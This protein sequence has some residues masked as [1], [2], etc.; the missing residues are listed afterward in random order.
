MNAL[1]HRR[2]AAA[3]AL[4][5]L[6]LAAGGAACQRR[7]KQ[8]VVGIGL[9]ANTH[10]GAKLAADEI[11]AAGGVDGVRIALAGLDWP[12]RGESPYDPAS[13][14]DWA[15]RFSAMDDLV[16]VVGHS[17]SGSTLSAASTYNRKGIPQIVTIATNPAITNI[18]SWTYRLCLSDAAQGPALADYAVTEWRKKRLALFYV[19]DDYGRALARLFEDR[20]R[21]L[22]A[23]VVASAMHHNVLQPEDEQ[24]LRETVQ[25]LR[26]AAPDLVVLFQRVAAA[27][28]TLSALRDAGVTAD[29]L[30]GD[31]LAQ[32]SFAQDDARH[33]TDGVRV[34]QFTNLDPANPRTARFAERVRKASGREADYGVAYAY[35]AIYLLRDALHEGGFTRHGVKSYLDRLIRERRQVE[36][37][38]GSYLLAADHDARRPL[39]VAEIRD[40][41]FRV[42]K[43]LSVR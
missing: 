42:L 21:E 7:P 39:Y 33:T 20:A 32:Y 40:G 2:L 29:V 9:A 25:D 38:T 26:Q 10:P 17:D 18:G 34:S 16:A 3:G 11:N 6:L 30:G 37:V 19:N 35:D 22:G 27:R 5:L 14:L 31:N 13:V 41:R 12:S 28:W 8:V 23:V 15:D 24:L 4:A 43:V 1:R 36:G